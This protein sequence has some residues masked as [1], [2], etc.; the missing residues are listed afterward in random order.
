MPFERTKSAAAWRLA[1]AVAITRLSTRAPNAASPGFGV[2]AIRCAAP[3]RRRACT[4]V[5]ALTP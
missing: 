3:S 5:G 1:C 2:S 4:A